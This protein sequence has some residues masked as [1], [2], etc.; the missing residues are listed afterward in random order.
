MVKV[1]S[2]YNCKNCKQVSEATFNIRDAIKYIPS[3]KYVHNSITLYGGKGINFLQCLNKSPENIV[4]KDYIF[5][6]KSI[7]N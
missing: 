5:L 2:K 6:E 4:L 7:R 1:Y 3:E